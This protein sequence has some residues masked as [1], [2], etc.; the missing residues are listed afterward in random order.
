MMVL[1][2]FIVGP[3]PPF[4]NR[5]A[6]ISHTVRQGMGIVVRHGNNVAEFAFISSTYPFQGGSFVVG[7]EDLF[8]V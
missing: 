4:R 1:R 5:V 2:A 7:G 6:S 3:T 8:P